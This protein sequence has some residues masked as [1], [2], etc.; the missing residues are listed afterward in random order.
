MTVGRAERGPRP[1]ILDRASVQKGYVLDRQSGEVTPKR[2]GSVMFDVCADRGRIVLAATVGG[3]SIVMPTTCKSW[4]CAP[5]SRKLLALFQARLQIGCSRL[6]TSALITV[7]YKVGEGRAW[8]AGSAKADWRVFIKT[9]SLKRRPWMR[10]PEVTKKG[11]IHHHLVAGIERRERVNCYPI[12]GFDMRVHTRRFDTCGCVSHE[13]SRAWYDIT[14]DSL[15]V[16]SMPVI[17]FKG[18]GAYMSKYLAKTLG[19]ERL[20]LESL[21]VRRRYSSSRS[22]P[23]GGRLS[24]KMSLRAGGPGWKERRYLQGKRSTSEHGPKWL[25]ERTGEN[26][27]MLLAAKNKTKK[28]LRRLQ[29]ETQLS[30]ISNQEGETSVNKISR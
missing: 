17:S 4:R 2:T 12:Y 24:L 7:T 28:A 29:R 1:L 26:L 18:V 14:G 20:R 13:L 22:W 27:T 19:G 11:M 3:E 10:I 8:D 23:G 21:G 15:I 6:G 5:C 16:H 30:G 25:L 9:S